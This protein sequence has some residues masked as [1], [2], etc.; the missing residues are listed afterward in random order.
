[1]RHPEDRPTIGMILCKTKDNFVVEYALR[2]IH[3]P[4]GVSGYETLLMDK[5]PKEFKRTLPTVEEI[6]REKVKI[7]KKLL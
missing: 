4:M 2:N 6:E 3:K 7:A 5:L 1:M